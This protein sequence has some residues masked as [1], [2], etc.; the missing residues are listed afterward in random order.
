M[1]EAQTLTVLINAKDNASPAINGVKTKMQG[2]GEAFEKHRMKI[3]MAATAIGGAITGIAVTSVRSAVEQR[4]TI[5]MLDNALQTV[6][7]SYEQNKEQIEALAAAQQAKTNFGDEESR[8]SLQTLIRV[9]GD[10]ETSM[11][12][13]VIAQD[14]SA[15]SGKALEAVTEA[16]ARAIG[17]EEA[18]LKAF[19]PTAV[20]GMGVTELLAQATEKYAGAAE[21]AFDPATQ[22]A[23]TF[24]DLQDAIGTSLLSNMDGFLATADGIVRSIVTWIERNPELSNAII[25]VTTVIGGFLIVGGPLLIMLPMLAAGWGML[26]LAMLPVTL[27]IVG[28]SAAIY[29]GMQVW[30]NWDK[31]VAMFLSLIHI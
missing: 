13:L 30:Q 6:G 7:K 22:L 16:L 11:Q 28:I 15:G 18:A 20:N 9:S 10:Y 23:Q 29:A 31:V 12:A 25:A 14:I 24:S 27:T 5:D 1:A 3:G 17:G 21:A 26:N 2:L 19:L 4:K 8:Q